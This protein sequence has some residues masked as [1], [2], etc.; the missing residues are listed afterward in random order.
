MELKSLHSFKHTDVHTRTRMHPEREEGGGAQAVHRTGKQPFQLLLSVRLTVEIA[1]TAQ[2]M[3]CQPSDHRS[4]AEM[5]RNR[6]LHAAWSQS[7]SEYVTWLLQSCRPV[8]HQDNAAVTGCFRQC[9]MLNLCVNKRFTLFTGAEEDRRR[10]TD[11][12]KNTAGLQQ[13]ALLLG[14]LTESLS[15]M[16]A[17]SGC[18]ST[19]LSCWLIGEYFIF[20]CFF[21]PHLL[22]MSKK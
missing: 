4:S 9:V 11:E 18:G 2:D 17:V 13:R 16:A 3:A 21:Y 8:E 1:K 6:K 19:D 5:G 10:K 20:Y 14:P 22:R 7:Q 15:S 12:K